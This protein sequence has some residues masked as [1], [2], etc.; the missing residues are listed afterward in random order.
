VEGITNVILI[1]S[2]VFWMLVYYRIYRKG[3]YCPVCDNPVPRCTCK[4]KKCKLLKEDCECGWLRSLK[5]KIEEFFKIRRKS[6][7][8]L[9]EDMAQRLRDLRSDSG[10]KLPDTGSSRWSSS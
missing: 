4:C 7:T 1:G 8:Q 5:V 10:G 2:T 3:Q 9:P 6:D